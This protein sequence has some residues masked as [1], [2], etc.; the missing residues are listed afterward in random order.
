MKHQIILF[1]L[2]FLFLYGAMK[3]AIQAAVLIA[4]KKSVD[5]TVEMIATAFLG[6]T[7]AVEITNWL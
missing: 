7:M 6:A 1:G 2:V 5:V 4:E 3:T